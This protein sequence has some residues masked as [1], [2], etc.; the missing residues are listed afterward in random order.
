LKYQF[1]FK[2]KLA[3]LEE[4]QKQAVL[5]NKNKIISLKEVQNGLTEKRPY[6]LILFNAIKII[7]P[8]CSW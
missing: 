2:Q 1:A 4:E 7:L 6:F 8:L 5:S 3:V